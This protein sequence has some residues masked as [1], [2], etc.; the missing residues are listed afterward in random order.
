M[1]KYFKF[2]KPTDGYREERQ[3]ATQWKKTEKKK[4]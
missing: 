1:A 4:V 2:I 3:I